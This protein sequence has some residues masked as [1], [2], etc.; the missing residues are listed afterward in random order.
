MA[1]LQPCL[2]SSCENPSPKSSSDAISSK[3]IFDVL[4]ASPV[5]VDLY[6]IHPHKI[7]TQKRLKYVFLRS[8]KLF[9]PVFGRHNRQESFVK[10]VL[11]VFV[12]LDPQQRRPQKTS[13]RVRA[14]LC[15]VEAP[16]ASMWRDAVVSCKICPPINPNSKDLQ[17]TR[18]GILEHS[19]CA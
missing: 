18:F 13:N 9:C 19:V 6:L 15:A 11:A 17:P 7:L 12:H 1:V 16:A 4:K 3:R 5:S 14:G 10:Q 2:H 8:W